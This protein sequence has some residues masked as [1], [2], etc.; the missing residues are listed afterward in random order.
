MT[1][2]ELQQLQD[3]LAKYEKHSMKSN[4]KFVNKETLDWHIGCVKQCV[5]LH[6]L[7]K[8]YAMEDK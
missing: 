4:N 3:L 1:T 8:Q 2:E 7:D 5:R 6:E